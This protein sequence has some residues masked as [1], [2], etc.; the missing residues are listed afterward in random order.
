MAFLV[1]TK[2]RRLTIIMMNFMITVD[3][4]SLKVGLKYSIRNESERVME[5]NI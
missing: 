1:I 4:G 2:A 5:M 3:G